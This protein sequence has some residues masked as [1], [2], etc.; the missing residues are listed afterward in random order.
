MTYSNTPLSNQTPAASQPQMQQ[1]FLQ[2]ATSYNIDHVP[3][4]S[5][6]NVGQH[7]QVTLANV[8]AGDPGKVAPISSI[9]SKTVSMNPQ[10]FFQNGTL[11]ANV[12]QL[13]GSVT[14][15][16]NG[17]GQTEYSIVTPF[18]L[19]L[20]FGIGKANFAGFP[21]TFAT[22]F[23]TTVLGI[24]ATISAGANQQYSTNLAVTGINAWTGYL[25][26]AG[27]GTQLVY[28]VAWGN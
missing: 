19:T 25:T 28:Y 20:K 8:L 27:P 26:S 2:I 16:I 14:S 4:T 1:N 23:T 5:G 12:M 9:Y 7:Q 17:S 24:V 3:L 18:G 10:L 15:G 21:N 22:N 11:A 13:T 6:T